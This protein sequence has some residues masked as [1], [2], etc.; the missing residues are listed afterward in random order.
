[1]YCYVLFILPGFAWKIH[2]EGVANYNFFVFN[3]Y[4]YRI[5]LHAYIIIIKHLFVGRFIKYNNSEGYSIGCSNIRTLC[6][7][8]I[9]QFIWKIKKTIT[10]LFDE[11]DRERDR[12]TR[13]WIYFKMRFKNHRKQAFLETY[14]IKA[15]KHFKSCCVQL[16]DFFPGRKS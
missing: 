1:M 12:E 5:R 4:I 13:L 9:H 15:Q 14:H 6:E 2:Y 10:A 3:F 7:M 8:F 16:M 11:P